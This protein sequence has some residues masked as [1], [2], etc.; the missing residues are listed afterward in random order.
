MNKKYEVLPTR[1]LQTSHPGKIGIIGCGNY[2]YSILAYHLCKQYGNIVRGVMDINQ[3]HA[4]SMSQKY[5]CAYY[6]DQVNEII[7]DEQIQL[8][9]IASNHATHAEYAIKCLEA[10]KHVHIEKPHAV[11][12]DQLNRLCR[13]M[14]KTSCKVNLGFNRPKNKLGKALIKLVKEQSGTGM[15]NWFVVGHKLDIDNWYFQPSEGGRVLGNL[16]HWTDFTL[17][18]IGD[19]LAFPITINPSRSVKSDCDIVVG[20]VFGEQSIAAITFSAKEHTFEGVREI[21][22]IHKG[23]L[24]AQLKDFQ[25]LNY[26]LEDKKRKQI[27]FFRDHGHRVNVVYSYQM[28]FENKPGCSVEYVWNTG[29]LFLS[30]KKSLDENKTIIVLPFNDSYIRKQHES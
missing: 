14:E 22:S 29:N 3:H 19:E 5:R 2:S 15:F 7:N 30:T 18:L 12:F 25:C 20:Y 10:G 16:C 8:V 24:L 23:N 28:A 17:Q 21:L 1:I 27:S 13:A 6:T 4:A 9:Y 11:T 26:E